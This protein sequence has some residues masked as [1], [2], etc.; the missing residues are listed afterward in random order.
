[1]ARIVFTANLQRHLA[2][3]PQDVP[4]AS[5]REVLEAAFAANPRLRGYI[6]DDQGRLRRHVVVFVDGQTIQDRDGLGDAVR[7][8]S[9]LYVMQALSGG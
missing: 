8:D 3:E 4:G 6:L 7:T 9:E 5:V 1:M 2:A